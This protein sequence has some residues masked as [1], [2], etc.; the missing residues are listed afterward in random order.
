M[1]PIEYQVV[2]NLQTALFAITLAGGYHYSIGAT[3]VKLDPNADIEAL[4]GDQALRPFVILE[5]QPDS[6]LI[7]GTS[8]NRAEIKL[9]V[10]IHWVSEA[11]E[12]DDEARILT[13]FRGCA[14]VERAITV[15]ITRGNL[16]FDTRI[17]Q[18]RLDRVIDGSQVWAMVDVDIAVKR[19]YGQP[20]R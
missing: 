14:D 9:P 15:D 20:D 10:T 7:G 3:A 1:E 6:W 17:V 19:E 2:R 12:L 13:F 5:V 11:D 18:R 16:A 4:I 8:K